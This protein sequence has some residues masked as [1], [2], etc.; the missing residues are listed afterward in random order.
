MNVLHWVKHETIAAKDE[1]NV[2]CTG[3]PR[4]LLDRFR[5]TDGK[6]TPFG[7]GAAAAAML[8]R[9]TALEI[10]PLAPLFL[11][12]GRGGAQ[13]CQAVALSRNKSWEQKSRA[14]C[15]GWRRFIKEGARRQ[16]HLCTRLDSLTCREGSRF[17]HRPH[18]R[19]PCQ[20]EIT[21][22]LFIGSSPLYNIIYH[23]LLE[24]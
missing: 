17:Q 6:S 22:C 21:T 16:H 24:T 12:F 20:T 18:T 5:E 4:R 15:I 13:R 2:N 23:V 10:V 7:F 3:D 19:L 11:S 8:R 14:M 9:K 1:K